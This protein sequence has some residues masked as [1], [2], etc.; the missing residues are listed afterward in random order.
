MIIKRVLAVDTGVAEWGWAVV[1]C[2]EAIAS[3]TAW[4]VVK[5]QT[6]HAA[7]GTLNAI[8]ATHRPDV[9]VI[10]KPR[11]IGGAKGLAAAFS[12]DVVELAIMA[13][14]MMVGAGE[15]RGEFATPQDWKGS[16]PKGIME[17]RIRS[18]IDL[19]GARSHAI[20]AIGIALWRLG[21]LKP[22]LKG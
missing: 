10:E 3:V 18:I 15:K 22:P 21:L 11:V 19:N 14:A 1:D 20:D 16:V 5:R 13:G 12:G 17:R 2:E 4:D 6:I 9:V 8:G 7:C